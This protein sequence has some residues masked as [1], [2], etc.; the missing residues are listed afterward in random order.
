MN[1]QQYI[2][3][4]DLVFAT[5]IMK[6]LY[7]FVCLLQLMDKCVITSNHG[8]LS[9]TYLPR[10]NSQ[11]TMKIGTAIIITLSDRYKLIATANQKRELEINRC[12]IQSLLYVRIDSIKISLKPQH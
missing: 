4:S 3:S 5:I 1:L 9:Y 6:N 12:Y 8:R 2:S 11:N 10:S 7:K